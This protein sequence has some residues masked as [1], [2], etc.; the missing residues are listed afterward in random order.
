[1]ARTASSFGA[2]SRG[3]GALRE[4]AAAGRSEGG[5]VPELAS[6]TGAGSAAGAEPRAGRPSAG[7]TRSWM[8]RLRQ[9]A[10][11]ATAVTMLALGLATVHFIVLL[12]TYENVFVHPDFHQ[13]NLQFVMRSGLS[14]GPG[15]FIDIFQQREANE[16][17]PRWLMYYVETLDHKIRLWLYQWMPVYPTFLPVS[18]PLQL[19]VTPYL[20]YRLL[21]RLTG[22][23]LAAL[24]ALAVYLSAPGFLSGFSMAYMPGKTLSNL[25]YIAALYAGVLAADRLKPGRLL[26]ESKGGA[27]YALL[28]VLTL[29][30]FLDELPIA[31][32]LLLPCIFWRQIFPSSVTRRQL[33]RFVGNG[34]F[35]ALPVVVF[36][37]L[38]LVVAPPITEHYLGY[39][40]DYLSDLLHTGDNT[41]TG[42]TVMDGPN[43]AL[44]PAVVF[45]NFTTLFGV[46][47][48]P[49]FVSPLVVM[50]WGSYP[51]S[52][53]NNLPKLVIFLVFFGAAGLVAVRATG[54]F[55]TY[56]RGL[57]V[58][59]A[60]FLLFLSVLS[61]RHIPI[62]TGFYYGASFASLFA[63]L[64]GMLVHGL[65]LLDWRLRP[66]VALGV[67]AIVAVQIVNFWPV[68]EGWK[69][70]HNEEMTRARI[71]EMPDRFRRRFPLREGRPLTR[72]EVD[73]IWSSWRNGKMPA[74]IR[75]HRLSPSAAYLVFELR[76]IDRQRALA[77]GSAESND[78]D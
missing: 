29:G 22:D 77:N 12:A 17:R 13:A 58:G 36:L 52:Q 54:R 7:A 63:I 78:N 49:W 70:L 50:P 42:T 31:A 2:H 15:D 47:L 14:I 32:F 67:V 57:L 62:V 11:L 4:R 75:E 55:G 53:V 68:N 71:L 26:V 64:V 3:G 27:K 43:G 28:V 35:L 44:T 20:L 9:P 19:L 45:E 40:F 74:Y 33:L 56:F 21:M 48:A 59:I 73:G 66:Y 1:V 6:A 23:R 16:F 34:L 61:I 25:V 30:L 5:S 51:G 8:A 65:S 46:S 39:R 60:A 10:G 37:T 72:A 41:R 69:Q 38:V 76:E 24:A 18:W